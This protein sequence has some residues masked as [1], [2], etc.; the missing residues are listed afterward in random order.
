MTYRTVQRLVRLNLWAAAI[1]VVLGLFS[2]VRADAA[3]LYTNGATGIT[4][5]GQPTPTVLSD[6]VLKPF[7]SLKAYTVWEGNPMPRPP[8][9]VHVYNPP[10]H[11]PVPSAVPLPGALGLLLTVLFGLLLAAFFKMHTREGL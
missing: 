6:E 9:G 7:F 2:L 10:K 8:A 3:Y 1:L 4:P 11:P 5:C